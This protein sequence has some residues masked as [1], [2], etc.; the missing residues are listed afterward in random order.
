MAT[1]SKHSHNYKG[2]SIASNGYKLIYVGKEHHLADV[3]G[4]TY[5]HRVVM[6]RKL[7]RRLLPSEIVHHIDENK[8][9]NAPDNLEIKKSV[10]EHRH[11]HSKNNSRAP[12]EPN[13]IVECAC[14]CGNT[15]PKYDSVNRPRKYISGH[16]LK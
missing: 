5:E 10:A 13:T 1:I 9:N 3:R 12:G 16:N 7:G 14:G 15:F 4:Y 8:L 6:E 2:G 11:H